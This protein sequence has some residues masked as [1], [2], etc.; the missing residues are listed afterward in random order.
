MNKKMHIQR[1]KELHKAL[2]ELLADYINNTKNSLNETTIMDLV[3][4]SAKQ[5]KNP[6]G[7]A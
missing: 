1:H 5:L 2:D 3:K 4:W 6:E 7:V